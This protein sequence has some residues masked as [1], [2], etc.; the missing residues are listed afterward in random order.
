M[1]FSRMAAGSVLGLALAG[2]SATGAVA[3][4]THTDTVG[5]FD[6]TTK[7]AKPTPQAGHR[8]YIHWK[9]GVGY[10]ANYSYTSSRIVRPGAK[11]NVVKEIQCVLDFRGKN[12]GALD[13]DYGQNTRSAVIRAQRHCHISQ[14]G[15]VGPKTWKCLRSHWVA[16]G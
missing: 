13:G 7:I 1:K 16:W 4:P 2:A 15:I 9:Q 12:P 3:A 10:T 8:C 6:Q 5:S 11:G 14:D